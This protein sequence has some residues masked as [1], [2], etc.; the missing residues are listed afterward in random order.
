MLAS[1]IHWVFRVLMVLI[2]IDVVLS[3]FMDRYNPVRQMLDRIVNP[4]LA[5][6]RRVLPAT[7]N[8]DL[9]PMVLIFIL[10]ILDQLILSIL[11]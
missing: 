3:Y 9:S 11:R 5:P 1:I 4:M 8:L 6:I 7:G 2:L 10:W